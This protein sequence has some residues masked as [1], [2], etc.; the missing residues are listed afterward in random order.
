MKNHSRRAF[1]TKLARR[2]A[3]AETNVIATPGT[4][5]PSADQI[6][7]RFA[8]LAWQTTYCFPDDPLEESRQF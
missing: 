1:L 6:D 5:E 3:A 2:W 8:P 7:F 4:P